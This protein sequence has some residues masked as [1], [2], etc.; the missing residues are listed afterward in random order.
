MRKSRYNL[1]LRFPMPSTN[2]KLSAETT[3]ILESLRLEQ[4]ADSLGDAI[5]ILARESMQRK[6]DDLGVPLDYYMEIRHRL[7]ET[8]N[9]TAGLISRAEADQIRA[10]ARNRRRDGRLPT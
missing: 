3:A 10:E 4:D 7:N 5:E 6:A 2:V 9:G 1:H 8:R